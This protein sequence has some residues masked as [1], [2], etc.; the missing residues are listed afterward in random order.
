MSSPDRLQEARRK[1]VYD[2]PSIIPEWQT[3][4]DWDAVS[5]KAVLDIIDAAL[6]DSR[7]ER[8]DEALTVALSVVL[9]ETLDPNCTGTPPY[10]DTAA[11][12]NR[13][14]DSP[15]VRAALAD[16]RPSPDTAAEPRDEGLRGLFARY[17]EYHGEP[18]QWSDDGGWCLKHLPSVPEVIAALTNSRPEPLRE[19]VRTIRSYGWEVVD[20]TWDRAI[21]DEDLADSRPE[22]P[23]ARR[24]SRSSIAC[25]ADAL[26]CRNDRHTGEHAYA[27]NHPAI[28]DEAAWEEAESVLRARYDRLGGE[29]P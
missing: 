8:L 2:L 15:N 26:C 5:R 20:A 21:T 1:V 13:V 12:A 11:M 24:S 23:A 3:D 18:D 14:M 27:T 19:A 10:D 7:P 25:Q 16:S 29:T 17:I 9:H 6:A 4:A 22:P 28:G